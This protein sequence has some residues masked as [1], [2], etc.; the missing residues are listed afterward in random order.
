MNKIPRCSWFTSLELKLVI[1]A[2]FCSFVASLTL[3][4]YFVLLLCIVLCNPPRD[5]PLASVGCSEWALLL[6][7]VVLYWSLEGKHCITVGGS[8]T[9]Y[10][11]VPRRLKLCLS[12]YGIRALR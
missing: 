12:W 2:C 4:S 9:E 8:L 7:P 10:F 3:P 5:L 11:E 6:L 1:D